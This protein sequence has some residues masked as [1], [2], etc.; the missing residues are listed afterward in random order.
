MSSALASLW[1]DKQAQVPDVEQTIYTATDETWKDYKAN[2]S[3]PY[4]SHVV[5]PSRGKLTQAFELRDVYKTHRP[6]PVARLELVTAQFAHCLIDALDD[7]IL[8]FHMGDMLAHFT[9]GGI[10]PLHNKQTACVPAV[11]K[12]F[13]R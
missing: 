12:H 10:A 5:Y 9:V 3:P 7:F 13:Y 4:T 2:P 8:A 1:E 6:S 11:S